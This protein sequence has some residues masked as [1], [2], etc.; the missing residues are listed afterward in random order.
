VYN[1][2]DS[3]P[4]KLIKN[5]RFES[6]T[7]N[8]YRIN[9]SVT[10]PG[11]SGDTPGSVEV[12]V[13]ADSVGSEYNIS[14]SKFTIPGFKNTPRYEGFYAKTSGAISG[15]ISGEK[16]LVSLSDV[17]SAKDSLTIELEKQL[18]EDAKEMKKEGYVSMVSASEIIIKDNEKEL[19]SGTTDEYTITATVHVPFVEKTLFAKA[20]AETLA[21]GYDSEP[22]TIANEESIVFTRRSSDSLISATSVPILVEGD[23]RI[24]WDID[25]ESLKESL[26]GKD[27]SNFQPIM[28]SISSIGSASLTFSPL[29]LGSFP[30]DKNKIKIIENLPK[31]N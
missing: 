24:V 7:G 3:S 13:Y 9:E 17:N 6:E 8:I 19:L 28:K 14:S 25:E 27:S 11:K 18:K 15:G 10:V 23:P 22:V 20:L 31:K 30:K 29:W 5:T 4:Q 1:A 12:M 2:F 16:S 26:S 21:T